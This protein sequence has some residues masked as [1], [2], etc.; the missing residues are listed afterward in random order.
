MSSRSAIRTALASTLGDGLS[1]IR[2]HPYT[3]R[4]INPPAM[5]VIELDQRP[6]TFQKGAHDYTAVVR[7]L[8]SGDIRPAQEKIDEFMDQV[9]DVIDADA[10][11]GGTVDDA[12][13]SRTRGD[14]EGMLEMGGTN[15]FATYT[16]IDFDV[17]IVG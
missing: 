1:G 9:E 2:A 16:V 3:P 6:S 7:L 13:W 15:G 5:V 12:T 11:L 17:E 10:T 14:S 4:Q 8:V